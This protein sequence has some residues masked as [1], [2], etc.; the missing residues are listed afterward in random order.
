MGELLAL[1]QPEG[2]AGRA[3]F[4]PASLHLSGIGAFFSR[5]FTLLGG[6]LRF[7]AAV[8]DQRCL[9][10]SETALDRDGGE[11]AERGHPPEP[12]KSL[13]S[14]SPVCSAKPKPSTLVTRQSPE[15]REASCT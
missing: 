15:I 12:L 5:I 11:S 14:F 4:A 7:P 3:A 8:L 6:G 1:T 2:A 9:F 10:H 13:W